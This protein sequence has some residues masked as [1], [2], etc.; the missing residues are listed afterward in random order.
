MS[1]YRLRQT[2]WP[3]SGGAVFAPAGSVID[4]VNGTDPYSVLV[5]ASGAFPPPNAQP[6]DQA[7]YNLMAT[8]YKRSDI[9]TAPFADGIFRND[10]NLPT[11]FHVA[12]E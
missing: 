7:T 2:G 9:I 4:T 6:M 12:P 3:L 10:P 11:Y 5:R 1:R 8:L